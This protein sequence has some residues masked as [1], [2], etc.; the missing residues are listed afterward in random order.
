MEKRALGVVIGRFQLDELHD[1]HLHLLDSVAKQC[2]RLL[3]LVGCNDVR[4]HSRNP[5]SFEIRSQ[6]LAA[7]YPNACILPIHDSKVSDEEWSGRV[8]ALIAAHHTPSE[9]VT[10]YGSR[11]SFI[12]QYSGIYRTEVLPAYTEISA[13]ERR[14]STVL[15][16]ELMRNPFFRKGWLA[17]ILNQFPVTDLT[18]DVAICTP[19]FSK[20]L[21]GRRSTD[22][23]HVRFFGGFVDRADSSIEAA[24]LREAGEEVVGIT[25][26]DLT[27]VGTRQIDD[28]RYRGSTYGIMTTFF[29]LMYSGGE[30]EGADDMPHVEWRALDETLYTD[31]WPN[32]RPLADMLLAHKAKVLSVR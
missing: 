16:L 1:G 23:P 4:F 32:H 27:F 25:T 13:S 2:D 12:P 28:P 15:D 30:A 3:I 5:F 26:S 24:A 21:M 8:D 22:T 9:T 7:G 11:D 31:I 20:V 29:V 14:A 19:D 17:A 18:V 6:M 10:L